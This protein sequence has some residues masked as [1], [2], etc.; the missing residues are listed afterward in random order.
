MKK[1][2]EGR[3]KDIRIEVALEVQGGKLCGEEIGQE[4]YQERNM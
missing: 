4:K 2:T 1:I 3:E